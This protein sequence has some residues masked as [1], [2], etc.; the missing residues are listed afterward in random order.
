MRT[1]FQRLWRVV[2]AGSAVLTLAACG[3][4]SSPT[5]PAQPVAATR[6]AEMQVEAAAAPV[7]VTVRGTVVDSAGRPLANINIECVGDAHCTPA[8]YDVSAEGHEHRAGRTD[9]NGSYEVVATSASGGAGGAFLMNANGLGYQ[10]GWRQVAWPRPACTSDQARCALSV[11]F[12]L[13][14]VAD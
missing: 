2:P 3:G 14:A 8:N 10:V 1:I 6:A 9:A 4:A 13:T 12:A 11:N 5:A 7:S